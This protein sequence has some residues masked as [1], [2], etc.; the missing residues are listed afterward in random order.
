MTI[1][2][3]HRYI[4]TEILDEPKREIGPDEDLLLTEMLDSLSVMRLVAYLEDEGG[5][6]IPA[7]DVTLE[8]FQTLRLIATYVASR[9]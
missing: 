5:F 7:E 6:S 1:D 8:H 3:I 2:Q 4:T 9:L